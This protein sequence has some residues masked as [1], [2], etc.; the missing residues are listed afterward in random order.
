MVKKIN[1]K[2]AASAKISIGENVEENGVCLAAWHK[3]VSEI[4]T[5]HG[6]KSESGV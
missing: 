3:S 2:M 5:W 6:A 1:S 4:K